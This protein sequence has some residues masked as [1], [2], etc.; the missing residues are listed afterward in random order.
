MWPFSSKNQTSVILI[1]IGSSSVGAGFALYAPGAT[2]SM[3]YSVR[4]PIEPRPNED[5]DI[6]ML[7]TLE[8]VHGYVLKEGAPTMKREVGSAHVDNILVSVA[9]PWQNTTVKTH[10]IAPG[11]K[12]TFTKS[13]LSDIVSGTLIPKDSVSS[14]ESVI[15]TILNGYETS[16]PFD[17]EVT[18]ADL[19]I[20]SSSLKRTVTEAIKESVRGA[21]HTS[22]II[23][24]AFAPVAYAILR[25]LYPHE[26][27]FLILDVTGEAT[28]LVF[29]RSGLIL[30]VETLPQG[31]NVLLN[32]GRRAGILSVGEEVILERAA[33]KQPGYIQPGRNV[34]FGVRALGAE[35]DWLENISSLLKK[36][37]VK[38]AL[39]RTLFLLSDFEVREYLKRTL[40][41]ST[42]H[43][44]WLSDSPLGII[45][46][47][48]SQF[49]THVAVKALAQ[50]DVFLGILALYYKKQ[51]VL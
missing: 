5:I 14:G 19:V 27:D 46:L 23:F 38:H 16:D 33:S 4:L 34:R 37:A 41:S 48:A 28:D 44:L 49:S 22:A 25:D 51:H 6:A 8:A 43:T 35:K 21:Y 32:S 18:R 9:A 36:I 20:L 29:V 50:G 47:T 17:K 39:P 11:K 26:R 2:P 3:Y 40:D 31:I 13:M 10:T 42:L 7:R 24:T 45:P 1:D 12:F 15:A 30:Q